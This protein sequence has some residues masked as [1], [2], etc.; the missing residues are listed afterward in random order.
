MIKFSLCITSQEPLVFVDIVQYRYYSPLAL[1]IFYFDALAMT[2]Q[3][4]YVVE[5]LTILLLTVVNFHPLMWSKHSP[6]CTI[7][8]PFLKKVQTPPLARLRDL[9]WN[10]GPKLKLEHP[11]LSP[12]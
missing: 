3:F 7:L 1:W 12:W 11:F 9:E 2:Q 6:E 5:T 10:I 4:I 8:V